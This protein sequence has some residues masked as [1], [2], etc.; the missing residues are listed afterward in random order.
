M[1]CGDGNVLADLLPL[2]MFDTKA[3]FSRLL[4]YFLSTPP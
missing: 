3:I 1:E 2:T 4:N